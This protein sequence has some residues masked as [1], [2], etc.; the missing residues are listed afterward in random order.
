MTGATL[1]GG[2]GCSTV[3]T[4]GDP[5]RF[6]RQARSR[7]LLEDLFTEGEVREVPERPALD[8]QPTEIVL[9]FLL[10]Q[11]D[12]GEAR[13][14]AREYL[15]RAEVW[16]ESGDAYIYS[17]VQR[18]EVE[19]SQGRGTRR[20]R[21]TFDVVGR[22]SSK[23]EFVP[24]LRRVTK[25]YVV[26]GSRGQWRL[27]QVPRGLWI[28]S[29][30]VKQAF[31][32]LVTYYVA[33]DGQRLVPD[34]VYLSRTSGE[35]VAA[36]VQRLIDGPGPWLKG[37]VNTRFPSGTRLRDA[38]LDGGILELDFSDEINQAG[39]T[40]RQRLVA[41][42][43]WTLTSPQLSLRILA[44][45]DP[46]VIDVD[47]EP[48]AIQREDTWS[49]YDPDATEV[50]RPIY[51]NR[52]RRLVALRPP[53]EIDPIRRSLPAGAMPVVDHTATRLA[54][55]RPRGRQTEL[56][57]GDVEKGPLEVRLRGRRL[58][59]PTW[60]TGDDGAWVV[61]HD[62]AGKSQ[63]WVVPASGGK[64]RSV[65]TLASGGRIHAFEL[66]RDGTRFAAVMESVGGP[67]LFVG[68]VTR[69]P[70]G[71]AT[72]LGALRPVAPGLDVA[73]VAWADSGR[74]VFIARESGAETAVWTS[75]V[76]GSDL[77]E[78]DDS[79]GVL[80]RGRTHHLVATPDRTAVIVDTR[81]LYEYAGNRWLQV[82]RPV[83]GS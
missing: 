35:T 42:L 41:Q 73:T 59:T 36:L 17:G 2:V 70:E 66:A 11:A 5:Q 58:T 54:V 79:Q 9:G 63:V 71:Q 72:K 69:E 62:K 14:T 82:P 45:G 20:I 80:A 10:A 56:L 43:V 16:D 76:D 4:S 32:R 26:Q 67:R 78:L 25:D 60:G 44:A 46:F 29:N 13:R 33:P 49:S 48:G 3:P 23:G 51:Y 31:R 30:S 1:V 39:P 68:L 7:P 81:V 22:I 34:P 40:D 47:S 8:A 15:L 12:A 57:M 21:A 28:G 75:L 64:P 52:S 77:T 74:L 38:R 19:E 6:N 50:D 27:S 61:S 65:G 18:T 83:P 37:R 53:A 24:E 55:L